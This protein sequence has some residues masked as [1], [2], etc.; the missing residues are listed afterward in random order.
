[1]AS[2]P[3]T[4][5]TLNLP[6]NK[7]K[8]KAEVLLC[9]VC[10]DFCSLEVSVH[11]YLWLLPLR[12]GAVQVGVNV[13]WVST[14]I[15]SFLCLLIIQWQ[16]PMNRPDINWAIGVRKARKAFL[17]PRGL[18]PLIALTLYVA[19]TNS[20]LS[21]QGHLSWGGF[22]SFFFSFKFVFV[23]VQ[24]MCVCVCTRM[25]R[26]TCTCVHTHVIFIILVKFYFL[27]WVLW[28]ASSRGWIAFP[29][30]KFKHTSVYVR[31]PWNPIS[32]VRLTLSL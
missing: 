17:M 7:K 21:S 27:F 25:G 31:C 30:P 22:Q 24:L 5:A 10:L 32:R 28:V 18:W 29:G 12:C 14:E 6:F 26:C 9:F 4:G 20:A 16:W 23:M 3:S 1:M 2:S 15:F 19:F 11:S 13:Q 8:K